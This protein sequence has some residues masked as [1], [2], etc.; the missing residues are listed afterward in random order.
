MKNFH[1]QY[2]RIVIVNLS[3]T[4]ILLIAHSV[5]HFMSGKLLKLWKKRL[6]AYISNIICF[7]T[8]TKEYSEV[9]FHFRK[10]GHDYM[11][12]LKISIFSSDVSNDNLRRDIESELIHLFLTFGCKVINAKLLTY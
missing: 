6:D 10:K 7:T 4:F 11:K 5:T 3:F 2:F 1:Y 8:F 12:H 9:A